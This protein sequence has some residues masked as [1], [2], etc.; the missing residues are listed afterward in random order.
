MDNIQNKSCLLQHVIR[1]TLDIQIQNIHTVNL[2]WPWL[3]SEIFSRMILHAS[4]TDVVGSNCIVFVTSFS[5]MLM[6]RDSV[7]MLRPCD[8]L[9]CNTTWQGNVTHLPTE[10]PNMPAWH[11]GEDLPVATFVNIF[12]GWKYPWIS[13]KYHIWGLQQK[14]ISKVCLA[15][16]DGVLNRVEAG[17]LRNWS[18]VPA[19][20]K[21][22]FSPT[23]HTDQPPTHWILRTDSQG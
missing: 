11:H 18:S 14:P 17:K 15:G 10:W 20:G 19:W 5:T 13:I 21:P 23:Q 8:C 7:A 16:W 2:R 22:H 3:A 1:N 12:H 6:R 9:C 4:Y